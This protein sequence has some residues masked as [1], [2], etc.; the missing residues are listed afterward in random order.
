MAH[1]IEEVNGIMPIAFVGE[2]PWHG[3]GQKLEPGSPLE[4]WAEAAGMNWSL[5]EAPVLYMDDNGVLRMYPG[6]KMLRRS[7]NDLPLS[8]VGDGYRAVHPPEVLEF[9]RGLIEAGGFT[10]NTAGVLFSGKKFWALA[11]IGESL[12]LPG[13]DKVEGFLLLTTSCDGSLATTAMF[14]SIRV[15]CN[16]TLGFAVSEGESGKARRYLKIPHNANFD[17][18]AIKAEL[19]LAADSWGAFAETTQ[20]LVKRRVRDSEAIKFFANVLRRERDEDEVVIALA[21]REFTGAE[22]SRGVVADL[23]AGEF[24]KEAA[25]TEEKEVEVLLAEADGKSVKR[26]FELYKGAGKGSNL[27]SSDGTA[28]GLV[29]SVTQFIDHERNTKT[30]DNRLDYAWFGGG[31]NIKQRAWEEALKLAA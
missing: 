1:C 29:N 31:S 15:V 26:M 24:T 19:G 9:F 14:T 12:I 16:N 7:D 28:W 8:I 10:M 23:L 17:P 21:N 13:D 5:K 2:T 3:L 11:E 20:E 22:E 4:V 27:A 6:R 25:S 18:D 30:V